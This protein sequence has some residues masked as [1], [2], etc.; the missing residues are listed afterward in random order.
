MA[1][2]KQQQETRELTIIA[3]YKFKTNGKLNGTRCVL[4]RNDRGEMHK[5]WT[6]ENGIA[7][8]CECKGFKRHHKC[9]H[10]AFV[11]GGQ[12]DQKAATENTGVVVVASPVVAAPKI[13]KREEKAA[14]VAH[15][16]AVAASEEASQ[17]RLSAPLVGNQEFCFL[18]KSA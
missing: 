12:Q 16:Q 4:L 13:Q 2:Q 9:Y 10:V 5:V 6:H 8:H 1:A 17:K 14:A 7:A 15:R 18:K 11:A 3:V